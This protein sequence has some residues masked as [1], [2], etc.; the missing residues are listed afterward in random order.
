MFRGT[1]VLGFLLTIGQISSAQLLGAKGLNFVAPQVKGYG[2]VGN[3]QP[4]E[5]V[6]D[7]T[8]NGGLGGFWGKDSS[9]LG[10]I[11]LGGGSSTPVA[12]VVKR[13]ATVGSCSYSPTTG[14]HYIKVKMVG[15]GGGGSGVAA[16][17]ALAGGPTTFGPSA[18]PFIAG[19]GNPGVTG[20]AGGNGGTANILG[21]DATYADGGSGSGANQIV[22]GT[23]G[24]GGSSAFGGNGG[25]G[26]TNG[27]GFAGKDNTGGGGGGAGSTGSAAGGAGGG[28]GGYIEAILTSPSAGYL[29]TVGSNG[30][31]GVG[32]VNGGDGGSGYIEVT[33]Y[34]Q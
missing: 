9:T 6:F 28:A 5:I 34:F 22:N 23:G 31:G 24:P 17:A 11:S 25:G 29:C 13:F 18:S 7:T 21:V 32:G 26:G 20:G 12:P 3:P 4:G 1:L 10:W 30:P 16:S 2:N 14:L 15:G 27:A 8:T 19:G 33:E